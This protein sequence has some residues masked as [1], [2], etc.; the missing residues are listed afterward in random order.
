MAPA[1]LIFCVDRVDRDALANYIERHDAPRFRELI[2]ELRQNGEWPFP[3]DIFI[4]L[5]VLDDD[6]F[7]INTSRLCGVDGTDVAS[8]T[9]GLMAGRSETDQLFA[10]MRRHFP[11]FG[12]ARIRWVAPSLGVRETRRIVGD[13]CLT[14]ADLAAAREFDDTIAYSSYEWDLP[15]PRE[16]SLQ[17]MR[18]QKATK[19]RFTPVPYRTMLP[20]P[21][22]NLICPGRAISVERDVLGPLR[23]MA[24]CMAMGEAAGLAARQV[25]A[26]DIAFRDVDTAALRT[27]LRANGAIVD[28]PS[29]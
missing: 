4:S 19:P 17:P 21:I 8:L 10:L 22:T 6:V 7:A 20:L 28:A 18:E 11:G 26:G 29:E 3:Y 25:A 1:T 24:P 16:P 15:D 5:Q 13:F 2:R 23:V 12:R 27:R 14:V 9:A